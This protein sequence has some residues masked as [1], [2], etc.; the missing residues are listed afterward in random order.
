M[1]SRSALLLRLAVL[2]VTIAVG[3][4]AL[5]PAADRG[6]RRPRTQL[7]GKTTQGFQVYGLEGDRKL[8]GMHV[9]WRGRCTNGATV[10]AASANV[11]DTRVPFRRS[12]RT[13]SVVSH[14]LGYSRSRGRVRQTITVRGSSS[15]D[16]RSAS[17]TLRGR[18]AF[19]AGSC[20]SG[21]VSWR[22]AA[23]G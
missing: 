2:A 4:V 13:F 21:P 5:R 14:P 10:D 17:G 1:G 22:L 8:R 15:A 6:E 11:E 3:V 16:G 20:D 18:A 23:A 9:V 19:A 12:G 7:N